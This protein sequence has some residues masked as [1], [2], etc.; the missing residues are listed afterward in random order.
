[1]KK[2]V[3]LLILLSPCAVQ[4]VYADD[5]D[6]FIGSWKLGKIEAKSESGDWQKLERWGDNPFGIIMYDSVGNMAVQLAFED[7]SAESA[8]VPNSEV[9]D[10]YVTY[11]AT[12]DVN[13]GDRTVT[14]H[15]LFH[16]NPKAD[17][18]SVVR[19]Y[20]FDGN[21]LTLT[22][23]PD[24]NLRLTWIRLDEKFSAD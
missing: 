23:A 12:Y 4:I 13:S 17:G 2:I 18:L 8:P 11:V 14:H 15:R 16:T 22:V 21:T 5:A 3:Q 20:E 10:G 1:M 24:R 9:I 6:R 19:H 7:R